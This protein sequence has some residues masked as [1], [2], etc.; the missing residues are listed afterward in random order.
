MAD[1]G[2]CKKASFVWLEVAFTMQET[3][4]KKVG[5]VC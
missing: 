3:G 4:R 5:N 1:H 2:S